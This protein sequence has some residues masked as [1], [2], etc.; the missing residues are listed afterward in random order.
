MTHR[1]GLD[2]WQIKLLAAG[3]MLI[4]HIGALLFPQWMILRII[5]RL[6]FPLY[7][8]LLAEG[9][10]HTSHIARY[11]ARLAFFAVISEIPYDLAFFGRPFYWGSQNVFFELLFGLAAIYILQKMPSRMLGG[12]AVIAMA[13]LAWAVRADYKAYGVIAI[14]LLYL[15]RDPAGGQ[16][17]WSILAFLALNLCYCLPQNY[18][19]T[20][21][22]LF[23]YSLQNYAMFAAIPIALY[24]GQRGARRG[25]YFFYLFY[26]A[27]ILILYGF[28]LLL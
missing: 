7:C 3:A 8:L 28:Q 22:G 16:R 23:A 20:V 24:S 26:P 11:A 12:A 1:L 17:M 27:H 9:A 6:S 4:D 19:G 2:S 18:F 25:K 5:G 15:G 13:A 14:V 21:D 10:A